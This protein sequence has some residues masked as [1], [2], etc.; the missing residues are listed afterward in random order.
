[1]KSVPKIW[2]S[3]VML[4]T[5]KWMERES[6]GKAGLSGELR[7]EVLRKTDVQTAFRARRMQAG[8]DGWKCQTLMPKRTPLV[9]TWK[10]KGTR[11]TKPILK[12]ND[13]IRGIGLSDYGIT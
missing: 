12:K 10:G 13:E 3:V 11:I 7:Q 6:E 2:S 1:M 9:F 8:A 4:I 5:Q